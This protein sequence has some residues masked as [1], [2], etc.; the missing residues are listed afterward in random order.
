[1]LVKNAFDTLQLKFPPPV[2]TSSLANPGLSA[3]LM[4][5]KVISIRFSAALMGGFSF[6]Q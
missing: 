1:L 6:E 3:M 5:Q 2:W 4:T